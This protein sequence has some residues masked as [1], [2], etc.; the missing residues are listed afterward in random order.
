MNIIFTS[1][2]ETFS[3]TTLSSLTQ[4]IDRHII[5][6]ECSTITFFLSLSSSH[7]WAKYW[8]RRG[9]VTM[10]KRQL[11]P[12]FVYPTHSH[13][14]WPWNSNSAAWQIAGFVWSAST[15]EHVAISVMFGEKFMCSIDKIDNNLTDMLSSSKYTVKRNE[16]IGKWCK[17]SILKPVPSPAPACL[18]VFI[19]RLVARKGVCPRGLPLGAFV[20]ECL[21]P[22]GLSGLTPGEGLLWG[23]CSGRVCLWSL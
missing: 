13:V 19:W 1:V 20:L 4:L 11:V 18:G 12:D 8:G 14:L 3:I 15:V 7:F 23:F 9:L 22:V 5:M 17:S 21:A 10:A 2:W 16:D 6:N